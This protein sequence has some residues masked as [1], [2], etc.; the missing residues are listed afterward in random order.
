MLEICHGKVTVADF[1]LGEVHGELDLHIILM[2]SIQRIV[3][4]NIVHLMLIS[5]KQ[6]AV[7]VPSSTHQ[8]PVFSHPS[9]K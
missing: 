5:L 4:Q 2:L 6:V 9:L 8:Y 1:G 3:L 7:M